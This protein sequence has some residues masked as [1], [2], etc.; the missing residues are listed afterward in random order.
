MA[1]NLHCTLYT[2]H[3]PV[4][5]VQHMGTLYRA[6]HMGTLIKMNTTGSGTIQITFQ[7][8]T[9]WKETEYMKNE[10]DKTTIKN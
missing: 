10:N 5:K 8:K 3:Y 9:V 4:Y 1:V 7:K 2:L 6:Q